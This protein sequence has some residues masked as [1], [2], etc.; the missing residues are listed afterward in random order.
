M[1]IPAEYIENASALFF[2]P[3]LENFRPQ[4]FKISSKLTPSPPLTTIAVR[5]PL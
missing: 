4:N 5:H 1:K 3:F 2:P